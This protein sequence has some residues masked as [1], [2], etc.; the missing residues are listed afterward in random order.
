MA[1]MATTSA[2]QG[3]ALIRCVLAVLIFV[4]GA[5][6]VLA[7]GVVPFGGFLETRGFPL[8]VVLA[9]AI[10]LVELVAAPLLAWGRWVTPLAL[11][12]SA[13]YACGIWLVHAS[14]GWFVVGLGRN[15]A[16]YSVLLITGLL[17]NA[18][19][20]RRRILHDGAS[21]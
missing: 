19:A 17:A 21:R 2:Q 1:T 3:L 14:A 20:H 4:H 8:G 10:T 5:A 6:R 7:D 18:W 15:G 9:W 16:E 11:V 13:I 12:F